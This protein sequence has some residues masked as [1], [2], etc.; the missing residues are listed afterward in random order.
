[1]KL[2]YNFLKNNNKISLFNDVICAIDGISHGIY[3]V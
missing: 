1:M 2:V 3:C